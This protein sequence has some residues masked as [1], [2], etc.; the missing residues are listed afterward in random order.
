MN[1]IFYTYVLFKPSHI[2]IHILHVQYA[3]LVE[4]ANASLPQEPSNLYYVAANIANALKALK[5]PNL[6]TVCTCTNVICVFR[7]M[8]ITSL[9][10][11]EGPT[12]A[13]PLYNM[14]I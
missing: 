14:L 2:H 8:R 10:V 6:H 3:P 12:Y 5:F 4:I 7:C 9:C 13:Q 11:F 1:R